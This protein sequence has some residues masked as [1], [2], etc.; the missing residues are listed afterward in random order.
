MITIETLLQESVTLILAII[1]GYIIM[2]VLKIENT[3]CY[4]FGMGVGVIFITAR[5]YIAGL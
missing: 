1:I 4:L 2:R 5:L 3:G